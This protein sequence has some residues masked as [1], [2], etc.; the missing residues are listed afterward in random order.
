MLH[1]KKLDIHDE[2]TYVDSLSKFLEK[3]TDTV[4]FF[5]IEDKPFEKQFLNLKSKKI[6]LV[7]HQSPMFLFSRKEFA[8][9]HE[10]KKNFR[11][12]KM[13]RNIIK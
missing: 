13:H 10:G 7:E 9:F 2:N 12:A 5:E 8:E 4:N 6:N 1:Y 3:K 11:M